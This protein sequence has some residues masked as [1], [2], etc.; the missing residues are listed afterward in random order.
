[1]GTCPSDMTVRCCQL[2]LQAVRQPGLLGSAEPRL[3]AAHWGLGGSWDLVV[4]RTW[5]F[6]GLGGSQGL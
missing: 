4:L 2:V 1:M 6:S 3:A 5:W